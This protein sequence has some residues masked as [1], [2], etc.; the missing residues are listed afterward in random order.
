MILLEG[1]KIAEKILA[2]I[3]KE[4]AESE[5]RPGLGVVLVGNDEA[6]RIYVS[7]KEKAAQQIGINFRKIKLPEGTS[8]KLILEEIEKLN[9]DKN[10]HG[11]IVQL[12]LPEGLNKE[13]I[14]N[15]IDPKK[16]A[17]GFIS[18]NLKKFF[19]GRTEIFPVFP[20]AILELIKSSKQKL[21]CKKAIILGNSEE[22]GKSMDFM[23]RNEGIE[24]GYILREN[25]NKNLERIKQADILITACGEADLIKSEMLKDD[26]IV[27]D[28]GITKIDEKVVGD[29]D[30]KSVEFRNIFLTPVPG[31][32]GPVTIACLLRNVWLEYKKSSR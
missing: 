8:E 1:K 5:S 30:F 11:I 4:I 3:K 2:E 19:E 25:F 24:S 18:E 7:L 29:V 13:K 14:I 17:D 28:G 26:V 22:F 6:S 10:I 31:G 9:S 21:N 15:A 12:P 27:I 16:D 20:S 23:L 32:V